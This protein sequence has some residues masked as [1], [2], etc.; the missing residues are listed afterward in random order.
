MNKEQFQGQWNQIKGKIKEKWGNLTDDDLTVINGKRDQLVGL[1]QKKYGKQKEIVEKELA[2]FEKQFDRKTYKED[3]DKIE[4]RDMDEE[5]NELEEERKFKTFK[6][7]V[8]E[9]R[10]KKTGTEDY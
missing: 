3:E 2:E 9:D 8:T 5:L 10:G 4:S 6:E 1:L 7:D